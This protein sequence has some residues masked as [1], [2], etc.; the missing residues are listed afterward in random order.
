M[1]WG[2][3]GIGY[4]RE[5][6]GRDRGDSQSIH[7]CVCLWSIEVHCKDVRALNPL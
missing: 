5:G 3:E 7:T 1:L 2:E 6:G 4:I